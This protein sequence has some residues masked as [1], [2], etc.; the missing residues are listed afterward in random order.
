MGISK[1]CCGLQRYHRREL[2][3]CGQTSELLRCKMIISK[4]RRPIFL[5]RSIDFYYES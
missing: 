5:F 4:P 2:G 3:P 1:A